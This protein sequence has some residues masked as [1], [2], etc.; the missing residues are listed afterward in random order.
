MIKKLAF[1]NMCR[2]LRDY[3]VYFITLL[4]GVSIFYMFNSIYAQ[5]DMM[6]VTESVNSAMTALRQILSYISVFVSIVLGGLIVYAN[7]YFI[8]RRKKELGIYLILGME[9]RE[10]ALI[11][12]LETSIMAI[13]ALGVGL[14]LGIF[15]SQFM[16]F[17]TAQIFDADMTNFTFVFSFDAA[18]KCVIY[19]AIIFFIVAVFNVINLNKV[20]L[21]EL[22]YGGRKNEK[23]R[24]KSLKVSLCLFVISILLLGFAYFLIITNGILELNLKFT[25]SII[26]GISGTLL[27]F[28]SFSGFLIILIQKKKKVYF[29]GLNMFVTRQ[30]S[31]KLNTN[32]LSL[33]V[34]CLTLFL[35]ISIFSAGYSIQRIVSKSLKESTS[36]NFSMVADNVDTPIWNELPE[37]IKMEIT[38][39]AEVKTYHLGESFKYKNLNIDLSNINSRLPELSLTFITT[40]DFNKLC[41]LQDKKELKLK[42]NEYITVSYGEK[43][44]ELSAKILENKSVIQLENTNLYPVECIKNTQISNVDSASIYFVV[45]D[46]YDNYLKKN[47]S[48]KSN[49]LNL[50]TDNS[51]SEHKVNEL[52]RNLS[53]ESNRPFLYYVSR[54]DEYTDSITV[55]AIISFLAIYL[56]IVFMICCAAILAIQQLSEATDN[57]ERYL[58]LQKLGTEKSMINKAIFRQVLCYF[59]FP[60]FLAAAHSIVG[61][62]V[63][64][65]VI[66]KIGDTGIVKNLV[67]TGGF[68]LSIYA[69]YFL[70]T[71]IGCKNVVYKK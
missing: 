4:F 26:L 34:V 59:I 60:L 33:S 37:N 42:D 66:E 9:K 38:S 24:L 58:L 7:N 8:C 16:S 62:I 47:K 35:V 69:A 40:S 43:F 41:E 61:L 70:T 31:S 25:A 39:K 49:Y 18:I 54:M 28:F 64:Y 3:G 21:I 6:S 68:V 51:T 44:D 2:N 53:T 63:V 22:I 67:V 52:L 46:K 45:P 55:K 12:T 48:N 23:I 10:I 11:L 5:K 20:K 65:D 29:K 19:F 56:G 15:G 27:F 50:N 1:R 57:R 13:S 36:Y 14:L 71:Y 30:L 17:F 32:F